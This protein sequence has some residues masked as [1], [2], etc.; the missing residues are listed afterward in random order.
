MS[1]PTIQI[2]DILDY[3]QAF[4]NPVFRPPFKYQTT[5]QLY[6]INELIT[7]HIHEL[8][9]KY[10]T[11]L[12]SQSKNEKGKFSFINWDLNSWSPGMEIQCPTNELCW[13][14]FWYILYGRGFNQNQSFLLPLSTKRL[15]T[16]LLIQTIEK[17]LFS[18]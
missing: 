12:T 10:M 3:K 4:F 18:E 2:L 9:L 15:W 5:W 11:I 8:I 7:L 17:V 13:P 16:S 6:L 14:K 1:W